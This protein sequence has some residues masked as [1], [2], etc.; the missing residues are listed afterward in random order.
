VKKKMINRYL[1]VLTF[2]FAGALPAGGH[3]QSQKNEQNTQALRP[4]LMPQ[5]VTRL[6]WDLV[7]FN[8]LWAGSFSNP[9]SYLTSYPVQFDPKTFRFR[10]IFS[11][12]ERREYQDPEPWS[13]L[14]KLKRES[15]L[16]G[17]LDHLKELLGKSFPEVKSKQGLL[18]VEFTYRQ[19]GGAVEIAR[20]ENGVLMVRE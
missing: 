4:Y 19:G 17:A 14:S 3:A 10:A 2:V 15:V 12:A 9:G 5:K 8:L 6:D 1:L 18:L 16:R 11:V 13:S 7:Q 20:F